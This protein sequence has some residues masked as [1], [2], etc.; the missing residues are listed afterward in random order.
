MNNTKS[1]TVAELVADNYKA[2]DVFKK[3]G[4]DFC[5]GGGV[6]V[7][8]ICKRKKLDYSTIESE[9]LA[10]DSQVPKSHDF[11]NW[12]LDFLVDYIIQTHHGYVKESI[13]LLFQYAKKVARVH[14]HHYTETIEINDLFQ[15]AAEE[16]TAHMQKEEGILFPFIKRMVAAHKEG[17]AM[18][19]PPF[20]KVQNPIRMMEME[21]ENVGDV[22]KKIAEW[23]NHYQPPEGACNTFRVLYA[24]LKEFE[25]DLHQ[26]IHLEN[27]IL[28]PKAIGLE[29]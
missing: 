12:E 14:G 6:S 17:L 16:L 26:H 29:G 7:A 23:S 20:G 5:C 4:I 27:N 8:E 15:S 19:N 2:A 18:P 9:L 21:H 25:E 28:F 1:K 22:F 10:L 11:N 3:H 24:K 13:P